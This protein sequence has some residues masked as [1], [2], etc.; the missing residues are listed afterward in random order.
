[1]IQGWHKSSLTLGTWQNVFGFGADN[2]TLL[3]FV[4]D[5]VSP[6]LSRAARV[7]PTKG[8]LHRILLVQPKSRLWLLCLDRWYCS[9]ILQH[10]WWQDCSPSAIKEKQGA[11]VFINGILNKGFSWVPRYILLDMLAQSQHRRMLCQETVMIFT[12]E[13]KALKFPSDSRAPE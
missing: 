11:A 9:V 4:L 6:V 3:G 1:M 5:Q 13:I 12:A 8:T 10:C 2:S 7:L